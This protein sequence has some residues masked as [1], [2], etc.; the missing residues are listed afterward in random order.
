MEDEQETR[1][2]PEFEASHPLN[3]L[4]N[5]SPQYKEALKEY[6]PEQ[7]KQYNSLKEVNYAVANGRQVSLSNVFQLINQ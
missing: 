2:H 3:I 6:K 5:E 7:P 1:L 4:D